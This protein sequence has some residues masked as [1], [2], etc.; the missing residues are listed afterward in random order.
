[1]GFLFRGWGLIGLIILVIDIAAIVDMIRRPDLT[2]GKK[3]LWVLF[4]VV[5]P[6]IGLIAYL[7]A[8]PRVVDYGERR[9]A[10]HQELA[11]QAREHARDSARDFGIR[12]PGDEGL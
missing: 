9:D 7:I 5:L 2:G 1:M 6:V 10:E 12:K 8:R 11:E 3:A 4:I